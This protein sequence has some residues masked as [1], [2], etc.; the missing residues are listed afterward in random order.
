MPLRNFSSLAYSSL[1]RVCSRFGRTSKRPRLRMSSISRS[2][3]MRRRIVW[4]LV[5][6][7]P[8]QR[9]LT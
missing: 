9:W 8:S 1:M 3:S 6:I 2:R 4:K 5:S 7:P